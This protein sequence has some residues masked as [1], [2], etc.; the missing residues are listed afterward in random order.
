MKVQVP[1]FKGEVPRESSR[2]LP[3]GYAASATNCRLVTGDLTPWME[4]SAHS[5]SPLL[6]S[7][8]LQSIYKMQGGYVEAGSVYDGTNDYALLSSALAN[9]VSAKTGTLAFALKLNGGDATAM[10][11]LNITGSSVFL[12]VVRNA[13]NKIQIIGKN[14]AGTTILSIA[15]TAS[16]TTSSTWRIVQA[17]W[18]LASTT[19]AIYVADAADQTV[20]TR[21][22]DTIAYASA[23]SVSIGATITGT[24]KLN[25]ELSN[26]YF[27]TNYIDLTTTSNRRKFIN[28]DGTISP[29]RELIISAN[30]PAIFAVTGD[31]SVN[32]GEGGNFTI[33]GTLTASPTP[34]TAQTTT[35]IFL[36]SV[37]DVNWARGA[38]AGDTSERVYFTRFRD[39][40]TDTDNTPAVPK[41]TNIFK[42]ISGNIHANQTSGN[43]PNDWLL[44]GVPQPTSKVTATSTP[45]AAGSST[46]ISDG[47]STAPWTPTTNLTANDVT[48]GGL[49]IK[50]TDQAD[51]HTASDTGVG[52]INGDT[53][54]F[55]IRIANFS[56]YFDV[57]FSCDSAGN[58]P[59]VRLKTSAASTY[60]GSSA[61]TS[62]TTAS[63]QIGTSAT[64]TGTPTFTSSGSVPPV[65]TRTIVG[66]D[67]QWTHESKFTKDSNYSCSIVISLSA[68]VYT[69]MF[70]VGTWS[71][72]F[73]F[74]AVG[75]YLGF[76]TDPTTTG[77][78]AFFDNVATQGS[79]STTDSST[80]TYVYTWI[81]QFGDE[82]VPAEASDLVT[83]STGLTT[84]LSNISDPTAQQQVDRGLYNIGAGTKRLYRAATAADGS[85]DYFFVADI[86]YGTT[87]Y[88]DTLL[89]ANLGEVL[90]SQLY[91]LPPDDGHSIEALPNGITVM[92]SKNQICP[93]VQN[94]PHAYPEDYKLTTDFTIVGLGAI[95]TTIVVLTQANP[96]IVGGTDP[97]AMSMAKLELPY[98]CVSKRSIASLKG[99]GVIYASPNGLVSIMGAGVNLITDQLFTR[100]Q[101][102]ALVPSSIYGFVHDDRYF[103]FYDT[104][105]TKGGYL[106]DP[107]SQNGIIKLDLSVHTGFTVNNAVT[108][109]YSNPV[110]DTLYYIHSTNKLATWNTHATNKLQYVWKSKVYQLPYATTFE[111]SQVKGSSFGS[112]I[113]YKLYGDGT[114]Y[115]TKTIT[116]DG[117]FVTPAVGTTG[118][119]EFQVEVTGSATL[120]WLESAESMEELA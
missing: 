73:T 56:S 48:M 109:A 19:S 6:P 59:I 88:T 3:D 16:Y 100:E 80:T 120:S 1:F 21:T 49:C 101:W 98:G 30:E 97:A 31:P 69:A 60:T 53:Y 4:S 52:L 8:T 71:F 66:E 14:S 35:D 20:T 27:N 111:A 93:S 78:N 89:D 104:G 103:F 92:A 51:T 38:V 118:A 9:T 13:S 75:N 2:L 117:E 86:P 55:D 91:E 37:D 84:V 70:T 36:R 32:T 79:L 58:G 95:D 81:N 46:V 107:K 110:T 108:A 26:V 39:D 112:G 61:S 68:G 115:Y 116:A 41:V 65:S 106:F 5:L 17:S 57:K 11:I 113:T 82:G 87:T 18:D 44:L 63:Y 22:N 29:S 43:Y 77:H 99:Y 67:L 94:R 47:T 28:A 25:G 34:P 90:E 119:K 105:S 114:L 23:T 40:P 45:I 74:T 7:S 24:N 12:Q 72:S 62:T 33:T 85:T 64:W 15:T 10:E 83:I 96:Y 54:T 76:Q 42:A 50:M 102:Q